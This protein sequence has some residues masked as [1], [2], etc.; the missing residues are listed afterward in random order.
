LIF[1][2]IEEELAQ[3]KDY[4]DD[5]NEKRKS[6]GRKDSGDDNGSYRDKRHT[7]ISHKGSV[8]RKDSGDN[9]NGSYGDKGHT[10]ISHKGSVRL[11]D[12]GDNDNGSHR[13]KRHAAYDNESHRD[14]GHFAKSQKGSQDSNDNESHQFNYDYSINGK[15]YDIGLK[16][17]SEGHGKVVDEDTKQK[18]I[19]DKKSHGHY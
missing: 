12:S 4:N 9:D 18:R 13:E 5:D 10:V 15:G 16:D 19:V 11:K 8:R 2:F 3:G 6:H 1:R 7:A 14:N 17:N